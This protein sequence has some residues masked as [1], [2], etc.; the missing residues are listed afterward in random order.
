[1]FEFDNFQFDPLPEFENVE[2][3]AIDQWA[4]PTFDDGGGFED[5]SFE[6][7][8][9]DFWF[10]ADAKAEEGFRREDLIRYADETPPEPGSLRGPFRTIEQAE[11]YTRKFSNNNFHYEYTYD[12]WDDVWYVEVFGSP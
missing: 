7:I 3:P 6:A 10:L 9:E 12:G 11:R 5:T 8:P 4:D 2:F 1:M